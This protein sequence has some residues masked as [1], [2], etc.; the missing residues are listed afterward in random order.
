MC[1]DPGQKISTRN[2]AKNIALATS[3]VVRRIKDICGQAILVW[4][5]DKENHD[6]QREIDIKGMMIFARPSGSGYPSQLEAIISIWIY[7]GIPSEAYSVLQG[8]H[9][10][11]TRLKWLMC[12][13]QISSVRSKIL[14]QPQQFGF[15]GSVKAPHSLLPQMGIPTKWVNQRPNH[16]LR[17]GIFTGG[18]KYLDSL[19]GKAFVHQPPVRTVSRC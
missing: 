3:M 2:N 17:S 15:N 19:S 1:A 4:Y 11:L 12:N 6:R 14:L 8:F 18:T 10:P 5:P 9:I 16:Q 13:I 7:K